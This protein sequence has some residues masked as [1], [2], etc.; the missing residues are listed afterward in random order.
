[1]RDRRVVL[2]RCIRFLR[3]AA[4]AY[5]VP[6]SCEPFSA[7]HHSRA[8][9]SALGTQKRGLS[10]HKRPPPRP[11][12]VRPGPLHLFHDPRVSVPRP[13]VGEASRCA[14]SHRGP[15]VAAS[16]IESSR[17]IPWVSTKKENVHAQANTH[18][19]RRDRPEGGQRPQSNLA[20]S[21]SDM[22]ARWCANR[23]VVGHCHVNLG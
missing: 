16:Q 8:R 2:I 10:R 20:R 18:C 23:P 13:S 11:R 3:P 5:M 22:A 4:T 19:L 9:A 17:P 14:V 7:L 1:M 15:V 12:S 6:R 21:R